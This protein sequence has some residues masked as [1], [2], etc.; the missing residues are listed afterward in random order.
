[1]E[2]KGKFNEKF[3]EY[4]VPKK[5]TGI[6]NTVNDR[7]STQFS[8]NTINNENTIINENASTT[9]VVAKQRGN[10]ENPKVITTRS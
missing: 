2:A 6:K 1:M 8:K 7:M 3:N 5:D 4:S 9:G 10:N